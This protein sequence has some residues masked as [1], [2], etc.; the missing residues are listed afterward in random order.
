MIHHIETG[1]IVEEVIKNDKLVIIDF[2]AEW[3]GPCQMLT[4]VL[5]SV[6]KKYADYIE[7]FKVDVAKVNTMIYKSTT[8]TQNT[9]SG[10]TKGQTASYKKAI[11]TLTEGS[12]P[13]EFFE[14]LN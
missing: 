3:C 10:R 11:V 7:I 9:K 12:K 1:Q 2:F 6:D 13:I 14:S 8:K 5:R 4:E